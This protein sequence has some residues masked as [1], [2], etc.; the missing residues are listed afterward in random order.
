[1]ADWN[2]ELYLQFEKERNQPVIDLVSAVRQSA[3]HRVI[4]IGCGPGNSTLAIKRRFPDAEIVGLDNSPAMIE[5]AKSVSGDI[6]WIQ[7]DAVGDLSALGRFDLVLSNAAIQWM[8]GHNALLRHLFGLLSDGGEL[9]VQVPKYD[10]MPLSNM[11]RETAY[12]E[13]WKHYFTDFSDGMY[14]F[15]SQY[16]G[17]AL[18]DL[19]NSFRMWSTEYYHIMPDHKAILEFIRSTGMR[20]YLDRLPQSSHTEFCADVLSRIQNGYPSLD[21]GNVLF[22]FKRLF[23][24]ATA[25]LVIG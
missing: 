5:K 23:F 17:N 4:D 22:V 8:P 6:E 18:S 12:S 7:G 20:S 9:A 11:V 1:M 16:Y 19:T 24:I 10:E 21:N 2:P 25:T 15:S 13:T 3:P 14:Y